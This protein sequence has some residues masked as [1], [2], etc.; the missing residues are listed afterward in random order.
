MIPDSV[1]HS[2]LGTINPVVVKPCARWLLL[3][4]PLGQTPG[5]LLGEL[6]KEESET[7]EGTE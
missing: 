6:G 5:F 1:L 4:E 2:A 7:W 3:D